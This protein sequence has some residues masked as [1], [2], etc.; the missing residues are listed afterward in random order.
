M[1]PSNPYRAPIVRSPSPKSTEGK[2]RAEQSLRYGIGSTIA[3]ILPIVGVPVSIAAIVYGFLGL[4]KKK[5]KEAVIGILLGTV[6]LIVSI[7]NWIV[8]YYLYIN[9][10]IPFLSPP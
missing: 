6:F 3:W 4:G 7:G 2:R 9:G 1:E 8:G 10:K 5:R